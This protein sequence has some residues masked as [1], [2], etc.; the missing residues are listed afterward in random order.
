MDDMDRLLEGGGVAIWPEPAK[1]GPASKTDQRSGKRDRKKKRVGKKTSDGK[2]MQKGD[3]QGIIALKLPVI[4]K[5]INNEI[6]AQGEKTIL[7]VKREKK[8]QKEGEKNP[9]HTKKKKVVF[10]PPRGMKE[11]RVSKPPGG[12]LEK[13]SGA[14]GRGCERTSRGKI[15]PIKK[16]ECRKSEKRRKDSSATPRKKEMKRNRALRPQSGERQ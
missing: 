9:L 1:K 13:D 7:N 5:A 4:H 8:S 14:R 3:T 10:A 16:G 6:K 2:L 15:E 11:T 12:R